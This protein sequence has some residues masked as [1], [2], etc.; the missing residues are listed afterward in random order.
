MKYI[1]I[2]VLIISIFSC[3][4]EVTQVLTEEEKVAALKVKND[5][6]MVIFD[7]LMSMKIDIPQVIDKS[8]IDSTCNKQFTEL[9]KQTDG[10]VTILVNAKFITKEIINIIESNSTENADILFLIDKTSSMLD[11]IDNIKKGLN[12]VI[13]SIEKFKNNRLAIACYGDK[14]VDGPKWYDYKNFES[15]YKEAKSFVNLIDVTAGGDYPESFF[16]AFF[17]TMDKDF[18]KSETKRIIILIGDAPS[19]NPPLASHT[20]EEVIQKAKEN[21]ITMNFYPILISPYDTEILG[22]GPRMEELTLIEN[23][24][25]NPSNGLINITLIKNEVYDIELYNQ[26]GKLIKSETITSDN[27]K[28]D[29]YDLPNG[30]YVYRIMDKYKNHESKKIILQK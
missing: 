19:L 13:S 3:N 5:S 29:L 17:E 22:E 7:S 21:K 2:L 1:V 27:Y 12:N 11:D 18:W 26:E 30:V 23:I 24:Y 15:N 16:D 9:A 6:I 10:N 14:N 4:K 28:T 25:P 20:L 8:V